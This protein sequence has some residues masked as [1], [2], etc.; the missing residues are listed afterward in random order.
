MEHQT[1]EIEETY[2]DRNGPWLRPLIAAFVLIVADTMLTTLGTRPDWLP[3]WLPV[4]AS[5]VAC[6]TSGVYAAFT[7]TFS[8]RIVRVQA[9]VAAAGL[10]WWAIL[11]FGGL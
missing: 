1:K 8:A 11:R 5:A 3:T 4:I 10:A 2:M 9:Q 7:D 6:V